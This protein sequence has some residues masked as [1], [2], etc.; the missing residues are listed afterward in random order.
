MMHRARA[1]RLTPPPRLVENDVE[2]ACPICSAIAAAGWCACMPAR[3]NL[4]T[5]RRWITGRGHGHA[6]L[7]LRPQNGSWASCS[8]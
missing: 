5:D 3:S 6:R 8:R 7:C 4:L 2:R 1:F